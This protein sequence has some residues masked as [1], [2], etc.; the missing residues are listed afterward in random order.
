MVHR[1]GPVWKQVRASVSLPGVFPPVCADGDL[2]VDG[3]LMNNLPVD[4]MR[5][6]SNGGTVVAVDVTRMIDLPQEPFGDT[7]SGWQALLDR[8]NPFSTRARI[9]HIIGIL[10]RAT[11]LASV[12]AQMHTAKEADVCISLPVQEFGLLNFRSVDQLIDIGYR[13]TAA[14]LE[15]WLKT[16][17]PTW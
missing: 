4:V 9:P 13:H 1:F 14:Q 15:Q 16:H 7:V 6:V 11:E 3:A 17:P 12:N 8:L 5:T 2:L 10:M